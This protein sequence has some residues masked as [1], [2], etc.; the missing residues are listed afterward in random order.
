MGNQISGAL[1]TKKI[2]SPRSLSF[3]E[4]LQQQK[5]AKA[6]AMEALDKEIRQELKGCSSDDRCKER[7]ESSPEA[8][9]L[10]LYK[11]EVA[12]EKRANEEYNKKFPKLEF[13]G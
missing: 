8:K 6:K 5:E 1:N 12:E 3:G 4:Q 10:K 7:I 11:Q 9:K 2:D 13:N